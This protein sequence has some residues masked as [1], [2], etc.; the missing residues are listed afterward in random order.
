MSFPNV[1]QIAHRGGAG[2]WPENTL[3]AFSRAIEAG[4]DG[5]ELDVHLTLDGIAV[6]HHDEALKPAIAR[7]ADGQWLIPPTPLIKNMTLADLQQYDVGRLRPGSAYGSRYPEQTPVDGARIAPLESLLLLVKEKASAD[8]RLYI[9]LKTAILDLSLSASPEPL[10][11]AVVELVRRHGLERQPIFVSFDWRALSHA[12]TIAPEIANA[13]TTL[14]F[15]QIDPLDPSL[16]HDAPG[17]DDALIRSRSA[18]GAPWSGGY[19]WRAQRGAGFAERMIRAI[20]AAPADGWFAWYGDVTGEAMLP[21]REFGLSVSCWTV[22]EPDDMRRLAALRVDAILTDRPDRLK[23][24]LG[25]D[26][27]DA[28]V[29]PA[30]GFR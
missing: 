20:A 15:F 6:I 23:F 18:E 29:T 9:E 1:L 14:P 12:R 16:A 22:D 7:G 10:A 4:V 24:V 27:A 13:F 3:E 21:A 28:G 26:P 5:I 25:E 2:L 11:E 8:F 30:E 19:D 17:S